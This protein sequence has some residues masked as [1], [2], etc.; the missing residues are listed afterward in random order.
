MICGFILTVILS[1]YTTG[2]YSKFL[3]VDIQGDQ[4]LS[5]NGPPFLRESQVMPKEGTKTIGGK[6]QKSRF[7]SFFF[8]IKFRL[9]SKI[10]FKISLSVKTHKFENGQGCFDN[11]DCKSKKCSK[12]PLANQCGLEIGKVCTK[13]EDCC[14]SICLKKKCAYKNAIL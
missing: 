9:L 12:C 6:R 2:T 4:Q 8:Y 13:N 10:Y 3:L 7:V 1:I 5:A 11:T 14:S